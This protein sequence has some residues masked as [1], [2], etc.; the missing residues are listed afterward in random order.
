MFVRVMVIKKFELACYKNDSG[1]KRQK[2]STGGKKSGAPSELG[3]RG[4]RN[5]R[6]AY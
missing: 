6:V 1:K 3:K 5:S 4:R 2:E